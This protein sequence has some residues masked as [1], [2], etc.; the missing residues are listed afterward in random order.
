M[1]VTLP[2]AMDYRRRVRQ[3]MTLPSRG[4]LKLKA[5]EKVLVDQPGPESTANVNMQYGKGQ[6]ANLV[7]QQIKNTQLLVLVIKQQWQSSSSSSSEIQSLL[8]VLQYRDAFPDI[9]LQLYRVVFGKSSDDVV[10]KI[11]SGLKNVLS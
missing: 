5:T 2:A 4:G 9:S 7:I 10:E 11:T 3:N 8:L 6:V 1:K